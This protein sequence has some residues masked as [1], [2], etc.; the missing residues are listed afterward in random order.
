MARVLSGV[1]RWPECMCIIAQRHRCKPATIAVCCIVG[2]GTRWLFSASIPFKTRSSLT[3]LHLIHV[4]LRQA[5]ELL[6]CLLLTDYVWP[7]VGDRLK[8]LEAWQLTVHLQRRFNW[9]GPVLEQVNPFL[10]LQHAS[11]LWDTWPCA[12][13]ASHC[14]HFICFALCDRG[15]CVGCESCTHEP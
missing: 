5:R 14:K 15:P 8:Q 4:Q 9:D 7:G 13:Q 1:E 6:V 11:N 3:N 10:C 12:L 2:Q